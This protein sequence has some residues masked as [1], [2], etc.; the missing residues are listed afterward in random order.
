MTKTDPWRLFHAAAGIC[1]L[2]TGA[3]VALRTL[4]VIDID[5]FWCVFPVLL[6]VLAYIFFCVILVVILMLSNRK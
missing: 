3:L 4:G 2:I 5:P 6:F 1:L